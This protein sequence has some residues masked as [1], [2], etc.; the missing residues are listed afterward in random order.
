MDQ[1]YK[2]FAL[3]RSMKPYIGELII[4]GGVIILLTWT[5]IKTSSWSFIWV[6]LI[7]FVLYVLEHYTDLR[8][9][10][11]WKNGAVE[12]IGTSNFVTR[13]IASDITKVTL[14]KS[15]LATMLSRTRPTRR[16]TIYGKND[17]HLDVSLK[18]FVTEDIQKLMEE[19]HKLRPDLDIPKV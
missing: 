12:R 11:F 2:N 10:V 5:F 14:E 1:Q 9:R 16:I 6:I 17:Q 18:H 13:I 7:G 3:K 8:Y 15:D 4:I 19:I